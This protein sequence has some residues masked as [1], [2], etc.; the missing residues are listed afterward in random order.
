MSSYERWN[1]KA[2]VAVVVRDDNHS[3]DVQAVRTVN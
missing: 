1:A 3:V 2:V